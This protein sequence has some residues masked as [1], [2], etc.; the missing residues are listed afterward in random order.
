[1]ALPLW[2]L[3]RF[4][5]ARYFGDGT[6]PTIPKFFVLSDRGNGQLYRATAPAG[7]VTLVVTAGLTN[8]DIKEDAMTVFNEQ[9]GRFSNLTVLNGAFNITDPSPR[10][11]PPLIPD[12]GDVY[13]AIINASGIIRAFPIGTGQWDISQ[14]N[15]FNWA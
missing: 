15:T 1:M 10:T 4:R 11:R 13:T 3:R 5:Y 12:G 2:G 6:Y 7:V 8:A 14:W 9:T